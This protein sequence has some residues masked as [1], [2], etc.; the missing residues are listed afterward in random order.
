VTT[1]EHLIEYLEAKAV[2]HRSASM[3]GNHDVPHLAVLAL[4]FRFETAAVKGFAERFNSLAWIPGPRLEAA[5]ARV[6]RYTSDASPGYSLGELVNA[7]EQDSTAELALTRDDRIRLDR[8]DGLT[9][10]ELQEKYGLSRGRI[11][12]ITTTED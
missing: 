4:H 12:Q 8:E 1:T 3:W 7:L 10:T 5:V 9:F 11:H 2:E 6:A